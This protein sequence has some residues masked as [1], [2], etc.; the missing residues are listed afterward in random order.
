V[1]VVQ[2][3]AIKQ[4]EESTLSRLYRLHSVDNGDN[5]SQWPDEEMRSRT[6]IVD[7]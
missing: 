3:A 2:I 4:W 7:L 6:G 5:A 1:I